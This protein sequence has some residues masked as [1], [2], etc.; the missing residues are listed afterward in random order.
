MDTEQ[1]NYGLQSI[2]AVP[3]S[4]GEKI[5]EGHAAVF[6]QVVQI[7]ESFYEVIERG[8]FD[9]TELSDV[10]LF[11]NHDRTQIPMARTQSGTLVLTVDGKG[12]AFRASL[13]V[14]N[15]ADAKALYSAVTRG[16]I[17]GMSFAFQVELDEWQDLNSKMPT[18]C[19]K[20]IAQI[21]EI[22]AV[23]T[24][25]YSQT[26]I[27]ARAANTLATARHKAAAD[28]AFL[29]HK[30]KEEGKMYNDRYDDGDGRTAAVT[31]DD[32]TTRSSGAPKFIPGK[33]FIPARE[34][35][36]RAA[37]EAL[38]KR[39]VA[40]KRLKA[41]AAVSSPYNAIGEL[42][43][44]TLEGT[45]SIVVPNYTSPT[46][47]PDFSVVSTLIDGV[48]H[49]SLNGGESFKQPYIVGIGEGDYTGE[50]V[51]AAEAETVF[52]FADINRAKI[53]AYAEVSEELTKLPAAAYADT[54][55]AN[56]RTAMR[57]LLT[58]EILVGKGIDENDKHRLVGIFS[59][60]ATAIDASTDIEMSQITD[61]TL[62]EILFRYG[63]GED[64]ESQA[65]LILNKLDLLAFSKVRTSNKQNFYDIKLNGNS[66]AINSVPFILAS[67]CKPLSLAPNKGGAAVG[68]YCMCY[69]H[70][71]NY[72][73]VEFTP[74]EIKRSE[75]FKFRQGLE[76]FRGVCFVGGN[77]TKKNGFIR[78]RRSA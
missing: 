45:P 46:I 11:V 49:L 51:D 33:G 57:Q 37:D 7:G 38:E 36:R 78:V 29:K 59:D 63:G 62:D 61:T 48:A 13:D 4:A 35:D 16:D 71:S 72:T 26:D 65:T 23:T 58:K 3:N 1:R 5:I 54:V 77:V 12:L 31:A 14:E 55:F 44:M 9:E 21:F 24:P 25:A 10:A 20:K 2:R 28:I 27:N 30:I 32:A 56:I 39:E 8:A 60:K 15:N 69:G 75:D 43:S 52:A 17:R 47:N 67:A 68:D 19:I 53:T 34:Y 73:F 76:A 74:M 50:A 18:R 66:G 70:L 40:G 41:N 64:V 22:S 6:G 42:R